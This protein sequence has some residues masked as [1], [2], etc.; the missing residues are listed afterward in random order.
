MANKKKKA[1]KMAARGRSAAQIKAKTGVGSASAQRYVAR[2]SPAP[3]P[4]PNPQ[5]TSEPTPSASPTASMYINTAGTPVQTQAPTRPSHVRESYVDAGSGKT[6]KTRFVPGAML[7]GQ[8]GYDAATG[9]GVWVAGPTSDEDVR[10]WYRGSDPW[11]TGIDKAIEMSGKDASAFTL[12]GLYGGSPTESSTEI[13]TEISADPSKQKKKKKNKKVKIKGVGQGLRISGGGGLSKGELKT[14]LGA[15]NKDPGRVIGKLDKINKKLAGKDKTGITLRSGAANMLIKK[16]SKPGRSF[17][18]G[19]GAIGSALAGMMGDPGSPGTWF[20]GQKR[21]F[22][23]A[24]EPTFLAKGMDLNPKGKETV[25]GVGKQYKVPK[26]FLGDTTVDDT[27]VDDTTVDDTTVDDNITGGGGGFTEE[28]TM[29][30]E[31][32]IPEEEPIDTSLS[33]GVG[34]LDLASWATGFRRARS[35][36]QKAG[37]GAQGLASQKKSPFKSWNS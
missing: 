36:R 11:N 33:S 19:G 22:R 34:G 24:V 30:E 14:I 18:F 35:A 5:Q 27:T 10:A 23:E 37:K 28:D 4:A 32:I 13:S 2:H 6:Y 3:K 7:P 12:G 20:Q 8:R 1:K 16:G 21:G 9:G 25:R 17:D 26:R 15:S 31:P 29:A